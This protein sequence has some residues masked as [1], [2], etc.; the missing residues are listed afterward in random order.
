MLELG[1]ALLIFLLAFLGMAIGVLRGGRGI[2]GS[3]GGL[4]HLPGISSDCGGA[5]RAQ[6]R[7]CQRE[8]AAEGGS[9]NRNSAA[10]DAG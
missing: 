10:V 7:R 9:D 1:F 4:A 5:C 2:A 6:G 3:C 8:S